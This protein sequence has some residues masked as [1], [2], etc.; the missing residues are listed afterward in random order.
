MPSGVVPPAV[1]FGI[2]NQ[3]INELLQVYTFRLR[4][5]PAFYANGILVHDMCGFWAPERAVAEIP[6]KGRPPPVR[7][8][9]G[10][11]GSAQ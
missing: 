4:E 3:R 7:P 8:L 9:A 6:E 5:D 1:G 2:I 10:K 11:E